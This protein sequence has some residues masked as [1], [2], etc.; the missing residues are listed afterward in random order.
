M[1]IGSSS[2]ISFDATGQSSVP[3]DLFSIVFEKIKFLLLCNQNEILGNPEYGGN[4]TYYKHRL[5][6]TDVK[7][8]LKKSISLVLNTNMPYV[9]LKDIQDITSV[10]NVIGM[11]LII[12]I[13]E[14]E[15][16]VPVTI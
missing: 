11:S 5:M 10:D 12:D 3:K 14:D 9:I 4:L 15:F 8:T 13:N 16:S 6:K 7:N 2:I 1:P